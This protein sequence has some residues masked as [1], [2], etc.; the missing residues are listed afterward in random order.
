MGRWRAWSLNGLVRGRWSRESGI[1]V[2]LFGAPAMSEAAFL[3]PEGTTQLI[4][5]NSISGFSRNFDAQGRI[6]RSNT[7]SKTSLDVYAAHG[8]TENLTFVAATSTDRLVTKFANDPG[9]NINW[10]AMAGLRMPLWRSDDS[11]VSVQALAG[12]GRETGRSGLMAEA[13]LMAGHNLVVGGIPGFADAQLAWRQNAPGA[14]QE[15][16]FDATLGL[17]PHESVMVLVQV[18]TAYGMPHAGQERS[19]RLKAQFGLVWHIGETWSVQASAFHTFYG[20]NTALETGATLG[21]WRR[22]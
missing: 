13:R 11:I 1:V 18:F 5:A 19:V 3:Q 6:R 2:A 12:A 16:R 15:I 21:V 8:L 4:S 17:K 9:S 14:R 20:L 7:F 22:F 10:N